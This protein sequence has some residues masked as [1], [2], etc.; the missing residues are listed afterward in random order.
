VLVERLH[1]A[2]AVL[3]EEAKACSKT[4]TALQAANGVGRFSMIGMYPMSLFERGWSTGEVSLASLMA[5]NAPTS[6]ELAFDIGELA[7]KLVIGG[8]P[9]LLDGSVGD[10]MRFSQ[11]YISLVAEV[12]ISSMP[13]IRRNPGKVLRL[14]RSLARNVATEA[15]ITTLAK[16]VGG[17]GALD[18]QTV[19][20]YLEALERIMVLQDVPAWNTHVR[21]S[22]QLRKAAK[23]HFV[24]PSLAIGAL[25]LS[26]DKL[27]ADLNYLSLLFE[28]LALRDL[29]IYAEANGARLYHYRDSQ[30][31]EADG[32]IERANGDWCAF[33]VKLGVGAADEAAKSLLRLASRID[34]EK[35]GAPLALTVLTANGFAHRRADG[36][37]VVPLGT[38]AP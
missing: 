30:G 15:S 22:A 11:D 4:E 3:I 24:D 35:A 33:E 14:L 2:G 20:K 36:V 27:L 31:L 8:W 29:R 25:G 5:G 19:T 6:E 9:G 38:L 23:R 18:H 16:D 17:G 34:A 21:S 32:I 7:E 1:S 28:S 13:A 37:N 10:G 26:M 12:D